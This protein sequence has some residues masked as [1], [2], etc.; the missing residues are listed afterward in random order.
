MGRLLRWFGIAGLLLLLALAATLSLP[1]TETGSRWL[2]GRVPGLAVEDFRGRLLGDW[3]AAA[4][5]WQ[6]GETRMALESLRVTNRLGCLRER[7]LCLDELAAARLQIDLPPSPEQAVSEPLSLPDIRLPLGL[8][9]GRLQLG[10]L[11]VNGVEQLRDLVLAARLDRQGLQLTAVD[12]QRPDLRL[13]ISE[14]SLQPHGDW[15]LHARAILQLPPVDERAWQLDLQLDGR[16]LQRLE[17]VAHSQG[18]LDGELRGWLQP[19]AEGLPLELQ[20][21][22]RDFQALASLPPS[23]R[24]TSL[25]LNA[26]G[27]LSEGYEVSGTATLAGMEQPVGVALRGRVDAGGAQVEQLQLQDAAGET[28]QL[29]GRLDWRAA[30][31]ADL[32]LKGGAFAWQQ[33]YPLPDVELQLQQLQAALNY[34]DSR[35]QGDFDIRL[36]SPAG[37]LRLTSPLQGDSGQLQLAELRL[38]AGKGRAEG[39]LSLGFAEALSWQTH[40][41]LADL[42]PAYWLKE[43]PG[44]IGGALASNGELRDGRLQLQ[45]DWALDGEL[46]QQPLAFKG[47]LQGEGA[48][49][50]LP[51]LA[52][53]LGDNRIDGQGGWN[54]RLDG[55]FKLAL[56]RLDQLWPDLRGQATGELKLAGTPAAPQGSLAVQGKGL[57]YAEQRVSELALDARLDA[58]QRA[59]VQ[60]DAR[61]LRSGDSDFGQ[62]TLKGSG[63][64]QQ[65]SVELNLDGEPLR[66]TLAL[67]GGLDRKQDWRGRLNR[68]AASAAG[69]DWQLQRPASLER[70]AA[71]RITLGAHCWQSEEASLCADSQRLLPEPQLRLRLRD[72]D[73]ARLRRSLPR[74]TALVG[75]VNGDV[76]LDL[77]ASGPNGEVRLDAGSGQLRIR[78]RGEWLEIPYQR[79]LF[80]SQLRPQQIDS[81]LRLAGPTLG[82]LE[83]DARIDP[84]PQDKPLSGSF[85]FDGLDLALARP[86]ARQVERIEGR[87]DGSGRLSGSLL[88][89]VVNG[90][91]QLRDG[92]LS[93]GELPLTFEQL[94]LAL[95]ING[96]QAQLDGRWRSGA[97]G[98]GSLAGSMNWAGTPLMDLQ[99]RGSRLPAVIDPYGTLEAD[100]DLQLSLRD[101]QFT[102][103]G[104]VAVPRG[105]ITVR[106]LPPETVRV[107]E[108]AQIVGQQPAA[109]AAPG[110]KIDLRL[111]L[112]EDRL[113]FSGFGLTAD[114]KGNLRIRDNLDSRGS[115]DLENGRYRAYGQRLTLRRA[116]LI[117]AG[118]I[119]QPLLDIE[120]I[121]KVDDVTAGLRISGRADAP[122]S[123]VFSEPAMGQE[124]ALSYLVLG[125][126]PGSSGD[127]DMLSQ[128]ALALGLAG[129]T[130]VGGAIA[131]RLGIK[132]FMLESEGSGDSSSV[133]AS[134]Y[135]S[136]RLSLRYGVGVFEQGNVFALRYD[137]TKKLYLEAASGL[138]SSLDLFY[139]RDY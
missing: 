50:Q 129:G 111:A 60:L 83:L 18:Y 97:Q 2:L 133:A 90:R 37:P 59:S 30:F 89:P 9:I 36:L 7:L 48:H 39:E 61:G 94:Q 21:T 17:L 82:A 93:G 117:F 103:G 54:E 116:R 115:L 40:L 34:A 62:L 120:A 95:N 113:R 125:R 105:Q 77:P 65:H 4:L 31:A 22:T 73:L 110:L 14:L 8:D 72:F 139:K 128:A 63:S 47:R 101:N 1:A 43:L 78:E 122:V 138:A 41:Q 102:L 100:P 28:L 3:S 51:E 109:A 23:L 81:Q 87:I 98:Q 84:R 15:P 12:L 99:I 38:E 32:N 123:E 26:S 6:S 75:R 58:R 134:G 91:V 79:L 55:Q 44:R 57:G 5:R 45:A 16:L 46:R 49:W 53:R 126:A 71:G 130:P 19:L 86:F 118:P 11:E 106:D 132:D 25:G 68:G 119:D 56:A 96:Q 69:F 67:G 85:R 114:I 20:L 76:R 112:G 107:S 124:Q 88:A 35:Y 92:H 64:L 104:Q 137:L 33:L 127:S 10:S 24:F 70:T 52:L 121:R 13:T 66:L 74:G 42:D 135:L 108:D 27:T 80:T 136:E 29:A 131:E